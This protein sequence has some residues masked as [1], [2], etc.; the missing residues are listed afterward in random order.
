MVGM[1]RNALEV[2]RVIMEEGRAMGAKDFCIGGDLNQTRGWGENLEGLDIIDR[3]SLHGPEC[4]GCGQD[5]VTSDTVTCT[6]V[7]AD[8]PRESNIWRAWGSRVRKK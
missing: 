4:R 1:M 7:D 3:N 6:W 5:E 2:V 8:D